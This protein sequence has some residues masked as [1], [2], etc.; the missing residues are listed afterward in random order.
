MSDNAL[1]VIALLCVGVDAVAFALW[2]RRW[3]EVR[4]MLDD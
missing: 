2:L 4:R 1:A 3:P